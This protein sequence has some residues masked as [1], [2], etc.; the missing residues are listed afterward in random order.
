MRVELTVTYPN[1]DWVQAVIV[2]T[3]EEAV[4]VAQNLLLPYHES[5]PLIGEVGQHV[6]TSLNGCSVRIKYVED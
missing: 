6:Y 3:W 4:R 5:E 1:P 2:D